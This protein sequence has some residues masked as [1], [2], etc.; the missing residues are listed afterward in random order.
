MKPLELINYQKW[1]IISNLI[2]GNFLIEILFFLNST[3][4]ERLLYHIELSVLILPTL[5]TCSIIFQKIK[6][7][8][9]QFFFI[10]GAALIFFYVFSFLIILTASF[11]SP[12][13]TESNF[14][15]ILFF[16]LFP[17][18]WLSPVWIGMGVLN[19]YL[20]QKTDI[21]ASGE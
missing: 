12:P 5:L 17:A 2:M 18:I 3:A 13:N 11:L 10:Q 6:K 16:L 8:I 1:V 20:L 21:L 9:W 19:F 14:T 15:G 7:K 4:L